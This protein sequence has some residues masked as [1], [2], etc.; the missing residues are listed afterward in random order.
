[1]ALRGFILITTIIVTMMIVLFSN[2]TCKQYERLGRCPWIETSIASVLLRNIWK[3]YNF[4]KFSL[5]SVF[6]VPKI[7]ECVSQTQNSRKLIRRG[8]R[9][10]TCRLWCALL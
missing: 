6:Y 9:G 3:K 8:T 7:T 10:E 5:Q 2:G 1:M 4:G